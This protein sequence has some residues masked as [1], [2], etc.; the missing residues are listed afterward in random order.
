MGLWLSD[1]EI[2]ELV[3][4]CRM[5]DAE[6]RDR[7]IEAN[8]GLVRAVVCRFRNADFEE[9]FQ[10]GCLGLVKAVDR[11]DPGK[12]TRF[13]TYAFKV[14]LGEIRKYLRDSWQT[15]V[16]RRLKGIWR[17]ARQVEEQ[18]AGRLGRSVSLREVADEMGIDPAELVASM[19]ACLPPAPL[20]GCF[21][22]LSSSSAEQHA[23]DRLTLWECLNTLEE[24][25]RRVLLFRFFAGKTQSEVA[26]A[27]GLSQAQ[28]S[29]LESQALRKLRES[30]SC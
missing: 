5:G 16:P 3:R 1:A 6:A 27:I 18:L 20:E 19:E 12:G 28:V 25:E 10:V 7:L 17:Q 2:G 14:I 8:L 11:F 29:R 21:P 4:R 26:D 23:L 13:S 30:L 22:G 24:R 9:L 15:G